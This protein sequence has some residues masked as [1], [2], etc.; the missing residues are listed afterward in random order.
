MSKKKLKTYK[1]FIRDL[2]YNNPRA[3]RQFPDDELSQ[4]CVERFMIDD[5]LNRNKNDKLPKTTK[6]C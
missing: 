4:E 2:V 5:T 3:D 6:V 1:G